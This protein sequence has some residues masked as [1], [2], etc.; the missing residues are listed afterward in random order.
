MEGLSGTIVVVVAVNGDAVT[1]RLTGTGTITV[2]ATAEFI[3]ILA[4]L[5][6]PSGFFSQT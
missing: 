3:G 1:G 2:T 5:T 6:I 4:L